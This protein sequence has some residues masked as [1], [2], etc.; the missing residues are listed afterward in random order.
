[1]AGHG[2]ITIRS[3]DVCSGC[4]QHLHEHDRERVTHDDGRYSYDYRCPGGGR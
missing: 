2:V 4:G 3:N 1:M